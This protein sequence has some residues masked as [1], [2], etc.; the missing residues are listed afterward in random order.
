MKRNYLSDT[1]KCASS[2]EK[3]REQNRPKKTKTK[4]TIFS[5]VN[6][7]VESEHIEQEKGP[8]QLQINVCSLT[9]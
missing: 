3:N 8:Q 1:Q 5:Q 2:S 9:L 7:G 4:S 6:L